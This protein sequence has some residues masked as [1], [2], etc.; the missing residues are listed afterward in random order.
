M[1]RFGSR[2]VARGA[3]LIENVTGTFQTIEVFLSA[4]GVH[5]EVLTE[6][7]G[8]GGRLG[9]IQRVLGILDEDNPDRMNVVLEE[10]ISRLD[11]HGRYEEIEQ[12]DEALKE[13][14][15]Q[16]TDEQTVRSVNILVEEDQEVSD[17]L[18]DLITKNQE[19]L[20]VEVVRH[21]LAQHRELYAGGTPGPATSEARQV[22]EQILED[23]ANGIASE[24]DETPNLNQ[25]WR[26]RNYLEDQGFFDNDEKEKL[27]VGIYGYLSEVGSHPG[28]ADTSMGR[29]A[30][31]IL[32]NFAVYL[33]EKFERSRGE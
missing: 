16:V 20:T 3:T 11:A 8:A 5:D 29:M 26:V 27:V 12:L 14:G 33:L 4:S 24:R 2:V 22:I 18:D 7:R 28:V 19:H 31:V 21:H 32:L 23:I 10:L 1:V 30:H 15:F 13:Q 9:F 25:P 17:Y 6:S